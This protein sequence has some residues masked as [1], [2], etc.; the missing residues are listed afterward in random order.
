MQVKRSNLYA[1]RG[2]LLSDANKKWKN[3]RT[4]GTSELAGKRMS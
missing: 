1:I 4:A 2:I 3:A